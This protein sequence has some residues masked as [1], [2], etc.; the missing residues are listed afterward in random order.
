MQ[1]QDNTNVYAGFGVRLVAY[2]VD[3]LLVGMVTGTLELM[4]LVLS[5]V[6]EDNIFMKNILFDIPV[7]TI[8]AYLIQSFYFIIMTY[9]SGSTIGKKLFKIKVISVDERLS[10]WD[11]IYRESIGRYLSAVCVYIGYF[12]AVVDSEKRTLHDMLSDTRVVYAIKQDNVKST[13]TQSQI[14]SNQLEM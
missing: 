8:I 14:P 2:I 7:I 10:L 11:V 3:I 1:C 12:V 6:V 5:L 13:F 9:T 4:V